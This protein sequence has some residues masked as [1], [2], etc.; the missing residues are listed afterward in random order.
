MTNLLNE[1]KELRGISRKDVESI[2]SIEDE[3]ELLGI[4]KSAGEVKESFFGSNIS[5]FAPIYLTNECI[6][7]CLY[8]GFR[9][10]NR[11]L[12]RISLDTK[13]V[14][15]EAEFLSRQGHRRV[16]LVCAENPRKAGA[17]KIAGII[18]EIHNK[19][20]LKTITVNMAPLSKEEFEV[21]GRSKLWAYQSFQETYYADQY[22]KL[23]PKLNK[24]D[25]QW[26]SSTMERALSS[27]IKRVGL[28]VLFGLY[29]YK[30]EVLA[31]FDHIKKLKEK[32][33]VYPYN[34]SVPRLR[35]AL[36]AVI[37][38][39]PYPVSGIALKKIV[40]VLRLAFPAVH[41]ALSTREPRHLRNEMV[42]C[43]V[44]QMSAGSKTNPGG[45]T[46]SVAGDESSQFT[47]DDDRTLSEVIVSLQKMGLTPQLT[48]PSINNGHIG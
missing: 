35:P 30:F 2:L 33:D 15:K 29:D 31:L 21:L 4:F 3:T 14:L 25:Y 8:C 16:I 36:G 22:K 12:K 27:G 9:A 5:I 23:H 37:K 6:N 47:I 10:D 39:P 48:E 43:G 45:Y 26:R 17:D 38:E 7:N 11:K 42:R 28:G 40:A 41:I 13:D 32:F 19:T 24:A 34:I 20:P 18:D 1:N 46:S 44:S